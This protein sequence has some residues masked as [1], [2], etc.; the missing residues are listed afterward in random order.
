MLDPALPLLQGAGTQGFMLPACREGRKGG[1]E[2]IG[3]WPQLSK[4]S[5]FQEIIM[6]PVGYLYT[7]SKSLVAAELWLLFA[8][9]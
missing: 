4:V 5:F 3:T 8:V 7:F 9:G 1:R 2:P 6:Y